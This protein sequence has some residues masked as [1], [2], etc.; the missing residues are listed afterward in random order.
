MS[1]DVFAKCGDAM[2]NDVRYT[3][4]MVRAV[5]QNVKIWSDVEMV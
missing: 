1:D 3:G 4:N 5:T 2:W